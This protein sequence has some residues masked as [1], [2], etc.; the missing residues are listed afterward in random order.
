MITDFN[1]PGMSGFELTRQYRALELSR[2]T[3]RCLILGLTA[4]AARSR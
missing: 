3:H 2:G 4:D 1:M